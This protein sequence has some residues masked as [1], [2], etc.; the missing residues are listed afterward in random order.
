M[1]EPAEFTQTDAVTAIAGHRGNFEIRGLTTDFK[2]C[3]P[4]SYMYTRF[5]LTEIG[6]W[7]R[8]VG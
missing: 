8:W 4:P 6:E 7:G 1:L 3:N 5:K 2:H